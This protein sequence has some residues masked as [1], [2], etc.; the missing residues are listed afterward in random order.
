MI[1]YGPGRQAADVPGGAPAP[2]TGGP[3]R[4]TLPG[5]CAPGGPAVRR[6]ALSCGSASLAAR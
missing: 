6:A 1:R 2:G 5:A 3:A 4:V